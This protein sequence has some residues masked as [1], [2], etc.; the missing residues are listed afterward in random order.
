MCGRTPAPGSHPLGLGII[1]AAQLVLVV[2]V[3]HRTAV[4]DQG[5][6][7][8]IE[9]Q[10]RRHRTSIVNRHAMRFGD[11]I[12]ARDTRR[13]VVSQVHRLFAHLCKVVEDTLDVPELFDHVP[14][15]AYDSFL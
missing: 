8:T 6:A 13:R 9:R 12:R 11:A 14:G 2:E 7:L 4:L 5:Q 10:T 3:R 15:E 1:D